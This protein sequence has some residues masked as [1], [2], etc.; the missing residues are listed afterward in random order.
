MEINFAVIIQARENSKRLP[1][2][3]LKTFN[4]KTVLEIINLRLK[5]C[6][7]IEKII[8]AIPKNDKKILKILKKE[9][10]NYFLGS[11]QNVLERYYLC[12]KKFNIKNIIRITSD[13]PLIDFEIVD[14]M[15]DFYQKKRPDYLS[16]NLKNNFPDGLD[17]EI[18]N[19]NSLKEAYHKA[20]KT[21]DLE[22]V[23]F[24]ITDRPKKFRLLNYKD[25]FFKSF[26]NLRLTLDNIYDLN[27]IKEIFDFYKNN[28]YIKSEEIFRLM[29]IKPEIF[30]YN[31]FFQRDYGIN[32]KYSK[33]SWEKSLNI[34]PTGN[35]MIS[36]NPMSLL[37][38]QWP[39]YY[40]K[41]KGIKIWTFDN[42]KYFDYSLMGVGTNILGYANSKINSHVKEKIDMGSM[43]TLNCPE[44]YD[45]A[46]ELLK[47]NDWAEMVRFART[48]GEIN[49]M[50]IRV[51]RAATGKNKVA[52]CGY[53]GWH[54]WYI[55][56][57][58]SN[59]KN[60]KGHLMDGFFTSGVPDKLKNTSFAFEF[61]N[62]N[63][64]KKI[65]FKEKDI[66]VVKIEVFRNH[67][68][69]KEFLR[70]IRSICDKKNIVLIFDE[71]TSGFRNNFGGIYQKYGINPDLVL[72]GKALG[73]GFPITACVGK[74]NIMENFSKSFIS[75]TFW[76]ERVGFVAG[77][78]TLK[79][80]KRIRSWE[81]IT[82]LGNKFRNGLRDIAKS[83]RLKIDISGLP[84]LTN[85]EIKHE[86]SDIYHAFISQEM[87]KKGFL[88]TQSFYASTSHNT[89]GINQYLDH[90][91]KLF[92]IISKNLNNKNFIN[93]LSGPLP[94]K[95]FKRMN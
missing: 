78:A 42:K 35:Q 8:F 1:N 25:T 44:E 67:E 38:F 7:K 68:P 21:R 73:N 30:L 71:C 11:E 69:N 37:P 90:I 85:Y 22:H 81:K 19:F 95:P 32:K 5:K 62:I 88:S 70:E 55:S 66:G 2:K 16:N 76:T 87:L 29:K 14:K 13:C 52:F 74:R 27:V 64:L 92:K 41:A 53:H 40:K 4:G 89:K 47:I 72:F 20:K 48:G 18:F 63:S 24:Y 58:I 6:K 26:A 31:K 17:V 56:A 84:A 50:A 65:L 75:S 10:I 28:F 60:L 94:I 82:K 57:N 9:K 3:V 93:N 33:Y 54:D 59:N 45:L 61:N 43:T 83:N 79:E 49:S 51:A 34:I 36:K 46:E 23:T 39:L 86:N 15:I 77:L 12:A 80:M 91:D